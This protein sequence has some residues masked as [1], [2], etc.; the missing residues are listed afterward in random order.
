MTVYEISVE[1]DE[2]FNVNLGSGTVTP[3][4]GWRVKYRPLGSRGRW[5]KFSTDDDLAQYGIAELQEF[6]RLHAERGTASLA[7]VRGQDTER[8]EG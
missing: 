7:A 4:Q 2:G 5:S 6:C 8:G 3:W 1:R